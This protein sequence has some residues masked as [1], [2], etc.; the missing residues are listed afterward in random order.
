MQRRT[1][2]KMAGA[3]GVGLAAPWAKADAVVLKYGWHGPATEPTYQNSMEPF[4]KA[5]T[6]DSGGTVKVQMFPGGTLGKDP[7]GQVKY[8]QD[9][10]LDI[11]FLIPSRP[12]RRRALPGT[13]L[14]LQAAQ[15]HATR[16]ARR[17]RRWTCRG[18]G[19]P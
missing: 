4:G 9:G 1:L 10:V 5:V 2:M 14:R 11:V 17:A 6:A 19:R 16:R 3:A 7:S 18:T 15:P 13:A 12:C 8:L